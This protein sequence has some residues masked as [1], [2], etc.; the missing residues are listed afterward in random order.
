MASKITRWISRALQIGASMVLFAPSIGLASVEVCSQP[1][2]FSRLAVGYYDYEKSGV[3]GIAGQIDRKN[4]NVDLHYKLDETWSFGTAYRYT[5][6]DID[7]IELQTNGHLHTVSFPI[8]RQIHSSGGGFRLS[9]APSLSASSNVMKDPSQYSGDTFQALV[10]L[11]W[12][13]ELSGGAA[14]R[15]GVCGD[16]RFGKYTIYPSISVD[17]RPHPQFVIE[18]GFP[19]TRL[20]YEATPGLNISLQVAPDGNEWHVKNKGLDRESQL[21]YKASLAEWTL[22]WRAGDSFMITVGVGRLFR[23]RYDVTLQDGRDVELTDEAATRVGAA[24]EWRF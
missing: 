5:I 20:T 22:N 23:N 4:H 7:P 6:L 8:N 3:S 13:R 21:I 2:D 12:T 11:V 10:A 15:Y 16:H 24:L 14:L 17:W 18:M 9:V 1:R 19:T